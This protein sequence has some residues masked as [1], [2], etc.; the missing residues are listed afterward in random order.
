MIEQKFNE[1]KQSIAAER[2]R[3]LR[4]C[5][6]KKKVKPKKNS[7]NWCNQGFRK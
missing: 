5:A 6:H 2:A 4:E 7:R 1:E 3:E